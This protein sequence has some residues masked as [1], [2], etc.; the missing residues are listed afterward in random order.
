MPKLNLGK[1]GLTDKY[2]HK[3]TMKRNEHLYK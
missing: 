3:Y 1:E 2:G